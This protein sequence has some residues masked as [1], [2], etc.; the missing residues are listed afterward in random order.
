MAAISCREPMKMSRP[1]WLHVSIAVVVALAALLFV[2]L[3]NANGAAQSS[4]SASAGHRLA[5][6]WC[7]ECHSIEAVTAGA[8]R[9]PPAFVAIANRSSTTELSLKVFL[10][11][12]HRNMP[13]LIIAPNE[14]DDLV[15]YILSLKRN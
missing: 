9:G 8:T 7:S 1:F 12:S 11:T 4:D 15:N 13:N 10:Q 14:A 2:H 6:A 5:E 3:R